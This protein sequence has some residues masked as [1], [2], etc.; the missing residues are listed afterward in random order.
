MVAGC[1]ALCG[2]A[3]MAR[4]QG[5]AAAR[6]AAPVLRLPGLELRLSA[7]DGHLESL[8]DGRGRQ[9]AGVAHDSLG[10]WSAALSPGSTPARL[11]ARDA[12]RFSWREVN[13]GW[14]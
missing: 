7:T 3:S 10:L 8:R 2:L 4:G 12:G 11:H 5:V 9:L 13:G 6:A 14:L 1:A